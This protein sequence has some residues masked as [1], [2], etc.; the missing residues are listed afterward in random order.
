[1]LNNHY[2]KLYKEPEESLEEHIR[3]NQIHTTFCPS[4]ESEMTV[5]E[6][7]AAGICV[8]CY[9]DIHYEN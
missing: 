7:E 4:C 6:Y 5:G 9:F 2:T 3:K 8:D 1:M